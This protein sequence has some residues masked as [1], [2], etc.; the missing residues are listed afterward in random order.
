[1]EPRL[2]GETNVAKKDSRRLNLNW[3]SQRSLFG[4]KSVKRLTKRG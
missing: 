3:D 1:M 2:R 4:G